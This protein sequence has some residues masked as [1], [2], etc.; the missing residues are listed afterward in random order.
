MEKSKN[1]Q[2]Q[3]KTPVVCVK[4]D[5][6]E[7][8]HFMNN[9]DEKA[10]YRLSFLVDETV[11]NQIEADCMKALQSKGWGTTKQI[12]AKNGQILELDCWNSPCKSGGE[13]DGTW[14][15]YATSKYKS[16][17][18]YDI[19]DK[20]NI[21]KLSDNEIENTQWVGGLV[22]LTYAIFPYKTKEGNYT[23][24]LMFNQVG[25]AGPQDGNSGGA[26]AFGAVSQEEKCAFETR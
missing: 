12:K 19:Q 22:E 18:I 17:H 23:T 26:C 14:I 11:K 6:I 15:V 13:D 24:N 1:I 8:S 7:P 5:L 16:K 10:L 25:Y 20:S 21:K 3:I 4:A 2:G 9:T